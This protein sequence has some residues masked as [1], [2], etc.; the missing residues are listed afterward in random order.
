M[1]WIIT[2]L[3]ADCQDTACVPVCPVDC[4]YGLTVEDANYRKQLFIQPDECIDCGACEPECPWQAIFQD[5][6]VPEVFQED[7]GIN[8]QVFK[9]HAKDQFTITPDAI[10]EHPSPEEVD[11]NFEKWGYKK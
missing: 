5:S 9:D 1:A 4:I 3:C 7:I 6:Q 11:K 10:R 2:R 8:A